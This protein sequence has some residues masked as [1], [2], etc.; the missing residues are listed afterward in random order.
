MLGAFDPR[1]LELQREK[2]A[3]Q[4][5]DDVAAEILRAIVEA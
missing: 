1:F 5:A 4:T 2:A 3:F